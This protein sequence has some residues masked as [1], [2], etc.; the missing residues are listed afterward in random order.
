MD[1]AESIAI[2]SG[3]NIERLKALLANDTLTL[4]SISLSTYKKC[5]YQHKKNTYINI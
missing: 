2:K 5:L 1:L 3:V 4:H